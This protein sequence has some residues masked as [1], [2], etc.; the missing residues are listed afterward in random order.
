MAGIIS[1]W[2]DLGNAFWGGAVWAGF[3][4]IMK[5]FPRQG[6]RREGISVVCWIFI[7]LQ[8]GWCVWRRS[9]EGWGRMPAL[10]EEPWLHVSF[11]FLRSRW[12]RW[13]LVPICVIMLFPLSHYHV[14]HP[15]KLC[16]YSF[17]HLFIQEII[18]KVPAVCQHHGK[19]KD[20]APVPVALVHP[21]Q[22]R[23]YLSWCDSCIIIDR[24]QKVC[25]A[26]SRCNRRIWP[27]FGARA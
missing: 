15:I 18:T 21:W 13:P 16:F 7:V 4:E 27:D 11:F 10:T 23:P 12:E 14:P 5:D 2:N 6:W 19:Q 24:D 3:L 25:G 20:T 26:V 1:N 9:R 22:V 8:I 17:I